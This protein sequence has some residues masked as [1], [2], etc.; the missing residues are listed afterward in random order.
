MKKRKKI[1]KTTTK[2]GKQSSDIYP[3]LIGTVSI[4]N[5]G[6]GF[7]KVSEESEFASTW[8]DREVFIPA[9]FI[10]NAMSGDTVKIQVLPPRPGTDDAEKGPAGEIIEIVKRK[11]ETIVAELLPG[12]K[13]RPLNRKL[14]AEITLAKGKGDA[15]N[16][17][18]AEIKL[19]DMPNSNELIGKVIKSIGKAGTIQ[20]DLDAVCAEFELMP[21][22]T[23][24]ENS[25]A[26]E[27]VPREIE[28]KDFTDI[29]TA[30]IDPID[31]KDFDDALSIKL[32][33]DGKSAEL[34]IHISDVAAFITP[35]SDFDRKA[36]E[37]AFT[38]YLPGRTLPMLP[39][40]L[41]KAI[42]LQE[43]QIS[44][45]HSVIVNIDIE[46][47]EVLSF[48]RCHGLIEVNKRLDYD[49]VQKFLD[50]PAE[51]PPS[52]DKELAEKI[53]LLAKITA[54]IRK[55]RQKDEDF[56][57]LAI[58]E[59]RIICD[60]NS[61]TISGIVKKEQ[62]PADFI[63]E[64]C[65]LMANSLVGNE[66]IEKSIPGLFRIHPMADEEKLAEFAMNIHEIFGFYPGD[67][68]TRENCNKF[69]KNLPDNEVK[70]II[71][72]MFLRSLPRASY[73]EK[74]ELH[75]GLGK[76]KYV[77][78][79]SPIRRYTDLVV[80]Q[81]LWN[82]DTNQRLKPKNSFAKLATY[83]SAKE[84]NNDN[85]YFNASDRL[86]LRYLEEQLQ[87]R[88]SNYYSGIVSKIN[89]NSISVEIGEVGII[90]MIRFEDLPG[91]FERINNSTM[92]SVRN[93]KTI[94]IGSTLKLR[95]YEIDFARG[96]AYFKI[97]G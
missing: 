33:P 63:V 69:I 84:E 61:D 50:N 87:Q 77:H 68:S 92:Q 73:N 97:A 12:N 41:T 79:T 62:R 19:I 74:A 55:K 59:V 95:L 40:D 6:F 18:W 47:A 91:Y 27:I 17:D 58:P 30:T 43:N 65:M 26:S 4:S 96:I 82:F 93:G 22:Y 13:V 80:H 51:L 78:F 42:S 34:G 94:K 14:N 16:G 11:H 71:L 85:A 3:I 45:T 38:A 72:N 24:E 25:A 49:T 10:N 21:P 88:A 37:R 5:S 56:L 64:E 53:S 8:L 60:E 83:L 89:N 46:T 90:G 52:W 1:L 44:R 66:L 86:K 31:A 35:K 7:F 2:K 39:K 29:F 70:P 48:Y 54:A 75:F 57:D 15:K 20:G 67:L 28:R 76:L 23:D 32:A 9:K 36:Y 81:Q